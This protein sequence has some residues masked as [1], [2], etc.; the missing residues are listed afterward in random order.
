MSKSQHNKYRNDWNEEEDISYS[1]NREEMKRRRKQKRL[2]S[3][4]K[5][6]NID[7]LIRFEYDEDN[8]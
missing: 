3:A 8:I 5:T 6:R 2:K 7:E 4:L 1:K